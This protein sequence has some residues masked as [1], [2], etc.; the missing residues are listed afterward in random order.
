MSSSAVSRP[1]SCP[2]RVN[3]T[4]DASI[5]SIVRPVQVVGLKNP[6]LATCTRLAPGATAANACSVA[7]APTSRS[8][9]PGQRAATRSTSRSVP[10]RAPQ[11][12]SQSVAGAPCTTPPTT[13]ARSPHGGDGRSRSDGRS[14]V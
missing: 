3:T 4:P 5:G 11:T 12:T 13:T 14:T 10:G 9:G 6:W 1:S 7:P 2:S 8:T